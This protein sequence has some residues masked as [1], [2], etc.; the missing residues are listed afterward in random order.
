MLAPA[1]N[2]R[3]ADGHCPLM[4]YDTWTEGSLF[5]DHY[6]GFGKVAILHTKT[7]GLTDT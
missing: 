2:G 1:G 4:E 6:L 7:L 5:V 3:R